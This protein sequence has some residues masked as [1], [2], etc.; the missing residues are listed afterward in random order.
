MPATISPVLP[1]LL[2]SAGAAGGGAVHAEFTSRDMGRRLQLADDVGADG[3]GGW[4][5]RAGVGG[6]GDHHLHVALAELVGP[7]AGPPAHDSDVGS[8]K[9]PADRLLATGMP[10][11][12]CAD[13]DQQCDRDDPPRRRDG[14]SSDPL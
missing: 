1:S 12:P 3:A 6:D 4:T 9:P 10:K 2:I 8:W 7:A 13:H 5:L 14:K 11:M